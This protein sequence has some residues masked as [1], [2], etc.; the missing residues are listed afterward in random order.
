ML[1]IHNIYVINACNNVHVSYTTV[2]SQHARFTHMQYFIPSIK[3]ACSNNTLSLR[4]WLVQLIIRILGRPIF[5]LRHVYHRRCP[6]IQISLDL[7]EIKREGDKHNWNVSLPSPVGITQQEMVQPRIE[8]FLQLSKP[9]TCHHFVIKHAI[10]QRCL[11]LWRSPPWICVCC[12]D[13]RSATYGNCVT[14]LFIYCTLFT[15]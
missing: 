13:N 4:C 7:I 2:I 3:L 8:R 10:L 11:L 14:E 6:T 1:A 5:K 9:V 12:Q 15:C